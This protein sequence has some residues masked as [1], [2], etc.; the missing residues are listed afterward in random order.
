MTHIVRGLALALATLII[1]APALAQ[2]AGQPSEGSGTTRGSTSG[3][4]LR[5]GTPRETPRFD[6]AEAS[7]SVDLGGEEAENAYG[8]VTRT[9]GGEETREAP[10]E[11]LLRSIRSK[12]SAAPAATDTA[13]APRAV[14]GPDTRAR[15]TDTTQFPFSAVGVL[16]GVTASGEVY[17]CSASLIGPKTVLTTASCLY[18]HE[19]GWHGEFLFA[20]GVNTFEETPFGV[21]DWATAHLLE[22][23]LSAYDGSYGSV[24]PYDMALLILTEPAGDATGWFGFEANPQLGTFHANILGYPY[25]KEPEATQW[26]S[27]CDVPASLVQPTWIEHV[28]ATSYGTGGAP[29]YVYDTADRSRMI[30]AIDVA[31]G[32]SSNFAARITEASFDWIVQYWQ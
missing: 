1:A 17:Q 29:I 5:S 8:T 26:R 11:E 10:S 18:D 6:P 4:K 22:G 16:E 3:L 15:V 13:E 7:R 12:R 21:Y 24:L 32:A 14:F 20:P 31:E 25:D 2:E 27:N 19:A 30:Q 23:Y 9:N 28:C